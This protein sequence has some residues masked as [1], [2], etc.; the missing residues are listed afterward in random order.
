MDRGE[1]ERYSKL[2]GLAKRVLEQL[3]IFAERGIGRVSLNELRD[4]LPDSRQLLAALA[5]LEQRSYGRLH[6][7]T[8]ADP[9]FI[10]DLP[11]LQSLSQ[12]KGRP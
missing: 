11:Q 2:S 4:W 5:E 12:G 8:D 1:R 3:L 9:A 10:L 6:G 7:A